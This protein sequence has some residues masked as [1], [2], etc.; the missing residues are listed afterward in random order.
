[1]ARRI[2]NSIYSCD[3][4]YDVWKLPIQHA[5]T[6]TACHRSEVGHPFDCLMRC[7]NQSWDLVLHVAWGIHHPK[8]INLYRLIGA[9]NWVW[10]P[11]N[12]TA[13]NLMSSHLSSDIRWLDI[14]IQRQLVRR[15]YH[16]VDRLLC[17]SVNSVITEYKSNQDQITRPG[18]RAWTSSFSAIKDSGVTAVT[19]VC[20]RPTHEC[21]CWR[22]SWYIAWVKLQRS[23]KLDT[24]FTTWQK[25]GVWQLPAIISSS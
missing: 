15:A 25:V 4:S 8:N 2:A 7:F 24:A 17:F 9:S 23:S 3:P 22:G 18:T 1:M 16:A 21:C 11:H 5:A 14:P 12:D 19:V 13:R 10:V 6:E 20:V